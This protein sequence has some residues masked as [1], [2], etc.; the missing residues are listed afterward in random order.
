[1][2]L[3]SFSSS[4]G[5][6]TAR[7]PQAETRIIAAYNCLIGA[8]QSIYNQTP[9]TPTT[10]YKNFIGHSLATY[11]CSVAQLGTSISEGER[12]K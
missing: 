10:E 8:L 5:G 7:D 4:Y 3:L 1:M 9:H 12:M 11:Q 6:T 2:K